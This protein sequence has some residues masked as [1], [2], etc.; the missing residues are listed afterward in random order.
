MNWHFPSKSQLG[1]S[2]SYYVIGNIHKEI[3]QV[4]QTKGGKKTETYS[5]KS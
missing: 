2:L 4:F 3:A 1:I 5:E